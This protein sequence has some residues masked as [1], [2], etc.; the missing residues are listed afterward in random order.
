MGCRWSS[1]YEPKIYLANNA[2]KPAKIEILENDQV[3][4]R[5]DLDISSILTLP[6]SGG[7]QYRHQ[8][9]LPELN[10]RVNIKTNTAY[11]Y[12]T[13]GFLYLNFGGWSAPIG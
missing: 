12:R 8:L 7:N 9:H 6:V 11:H 1:A 2:T 13:N 10:K 5:G 4:Y 3:I